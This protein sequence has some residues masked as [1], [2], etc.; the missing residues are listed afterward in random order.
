MNLNT[1]WLRELG[2]EQI[3]EDDFG[4]K[5]GWWFI[6]IVVGILVLIML[7]AKIQFGA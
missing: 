2:T 1:Q 6:G 7:L 5:L 4:T 3:P